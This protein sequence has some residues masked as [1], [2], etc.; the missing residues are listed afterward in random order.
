MAMSW[1]GQFIIII[2]DLHLI[3]TAT[4]WTN[5]ITDQ[6]A[7]EHWMSIIRIIIEKIIPAVY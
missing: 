5:N 7:G 3:V 4:C 1:G 2:T 6:Q